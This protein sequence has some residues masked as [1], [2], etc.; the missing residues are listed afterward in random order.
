MIASS[1]LAQAIIIPTRNVYYKKCRSD[2]AIRKMINFKIVYYLLSHHGDS[3]SEYR[4]KNPNKMV[5]EEI[6][7]FP[8][9]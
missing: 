8:L 2:V 3:K 6:K 4:Q 9:L 7:I 1:K 5:L